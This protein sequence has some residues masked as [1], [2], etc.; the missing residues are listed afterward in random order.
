MDVISTTSHPGK[1]EDEG[2][3]IH[4]THTILQSVRVLAID[5]SV[6]ERSKGERAKA[7]KVV[8]DG[9]VKDEKVKDEAAMM[10]NDKPKAALIG[11]TATLELD[12]LQVVVVT[13]GEQAARCLLPYA[14]PWITA[15]PR[16]SC[17]TRSDGLLPL[18]LLLPLLPSSSSCAAERPRSPVAPALAVAPA[19]ASAPKKA[20][21]K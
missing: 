7:E 2:D 16:P 3:T 19:P 21:E 5:Q 1:G 13:A 4:I 11:R 20:V 18:L 9:K 12:A 8:K 10:K 15:R 14:R 6:D 17:I